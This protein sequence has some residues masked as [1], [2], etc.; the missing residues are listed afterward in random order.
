MSW[1]KVE[2]GWRIFNYEVLLLLYSTVRSI[3]Y[4]IEPVQYSLHGRYAP[5]V[6]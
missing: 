5:E 2:P 6:K 4:P 1:Y 3:Y